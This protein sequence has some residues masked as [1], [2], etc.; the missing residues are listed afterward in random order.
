M[1]GTVVC[2]GMA[3]WDR[4]LSVPA[5]P[6]AA[7]KLYAT[8]LSETGGGPAATA[9]CAI[10]RLGG[11]ARLVARTGEDA[12]GRAIAA[13]LRDGFGVDTRWLRLLPGARSAVSTVALDPS[14]ERL[15]LAFP[16][17]GLEVAPDWVDWDRALDGAG[18]VLADMGWP[19]AAER[20][21]LE[22]RAR[23]V[24]T[25]LDADLSPRPEARGLVPLAD[26]AVFSEAG[27]RALTGETDPRAALTA[28]PLRATLGVTLGARGYL[29]RDPTGW[30]SSP[31]PA[32]AAVD[33]LGAG[34]V[35]H[36]AFALA[37]AE[38]RTA[39]GAAR[40]A[41]AAAAL[42][43]TRPGGRQGTPSRTEVETLLL[44]G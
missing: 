28:L 33:T 1:G 18:C 6:S 15:I 26:H 9:A 21:L 37:L 24:P 11:A 14:G 30:H 44:A 32:I 41:N 2:V 40:L 12:T 19:R 10:A 27:L 5:L 8:A 38:G 43:C 42:K 17:E 20:A 34:D 36:G 29:W 31:A 23:G 39:A 3:V 4:I 16:G 7:T 35:F 13:E 25:V 22:A